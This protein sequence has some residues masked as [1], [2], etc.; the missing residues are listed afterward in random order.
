MIEIKL[1]LTDEQAEELFARVERIEKDIDTILKA[2]YLLNGNSKEEKN[3]GDR[4]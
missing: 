4:T 1:T 2:I 3:D